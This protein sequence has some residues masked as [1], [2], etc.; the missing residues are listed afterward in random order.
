MK[1]N[2]KLTM[3][4]YLLSTKIRF[5]VHW[6]A[7]HEWHSTNESTWVCKH[8]FPVKTKTHLDLSVEVLSLTGLFKTSFQLFSNFSLNALSHKNKSTIWV[9]IKTEL[10]F[11]KFKVKV[12]IRGH[13]FNVFRCRWCA[14]RMISKNLAYQWAH[15][16]KYC[17]IKKNMPRLK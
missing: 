17:H 13:D 12:W 14:V 15:G 4:N 8:D 6:L 10:I 5:F 3:L 11:F 9:N 1:H 16:K 2:C 7:N